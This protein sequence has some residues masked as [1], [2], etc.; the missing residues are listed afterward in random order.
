MEEQQGDERGR[1][2][3]QQIPRSRH[4]RGSTDPLGLGDFA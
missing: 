1:G 4:V 3:A 2:H